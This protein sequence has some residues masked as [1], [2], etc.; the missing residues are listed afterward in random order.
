MRLGI[1]LYMSPSSVSTSTASVTV[2][3]KIY[4]EFRYTV[5]DTSNTFS[6]SGD[7]GSDSG[8][9]S[10]SGSGQ[11]LLQTIS[12]SYSTSYTTT[13]TIDVSASLTGMNAT[14]GTASR[15]DSL[16]I[17]KRPASEPNTPGGFVL[18]DADVDSF[19]VDWNASGTNGAA[20]TNYTVQVATN[21]SMSG[22][23]SYTASGTAYT[24]TGRIPNTTYYVR[25]RANS[26][27]GSSGWTTV[28]SIKTTADSPDAPSTPE[29]S[30]IGQSQATFTWNAPSTNGASVTGYQWQ[31]ADNDTFAGATIGTT[32]SG[33]RTVTPTN[34]IPGTQY[35]FRVRANSSEGYGS[36]SGVRSFTTL[37]GAAFKMNDSWEPSRVWCKRT[38]W[39]QVITHKKVA[40]AW[41]V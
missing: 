34:L 12:K 29:V 26:S 21:S 14:P 15:S 28:K 33:T 9:K 6:Y 24:V 4:A 11:M 13:R 31:I 20:V 25:V 18:E 36:Y 32:A 40:G 2:T 17:P 19:Y 1:D 5:S 39:R 22:A 23:S 41:R 35:W 37:R 30:A 27:A 8:S 16:T 3:A 7:L 38:T 10:I